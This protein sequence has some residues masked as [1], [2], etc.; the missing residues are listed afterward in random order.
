MRAARARDS[1]NSVQKMYGEYKTRSEPAVM[2]DPMRANLSSCC[3]LMTRTLLSTALVLVV[4][5]VI[6]VTILKAAYCEF[7]KPQMQRGS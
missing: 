2:L 5:L 1:H 6:A 7:G 4:I 3:L